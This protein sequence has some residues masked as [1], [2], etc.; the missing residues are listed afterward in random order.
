MLAAIEHCR[1]TSDKIAAPRHGQSRL[2]AERSMCL[3]DQE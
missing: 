2:A 3:S 1:E